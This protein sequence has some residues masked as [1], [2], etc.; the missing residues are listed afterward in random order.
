MIGYLCATPY[1]VIA[2]TTLA[3]GKFK[4]EHN[5]LVIMDHFSIDEPLVKKIRALGIFNEVHLYKSNKKTK[6]NNF[7]RL[8]NAFF[9][10]RIMR[11][12]AKKDFDRFF[13]FAL[14]FI[15]ITYLIKKINKRSEKCEFAFADDGLGSYINEGIYTPTP[16]SERIL[17]LNGRLKLLK[18]VKKLYVYKPDFVIANKEFEL[19]KIPQT[20]DSVHALRRL[21]GALWPLDTDV[22]FDGKIL[23]FEQPYANDPGDK[24]TKEEQALI[25]LIQ[26]EM[27]A[28]SCIKM[29][30]RSFGDAKWEHFDVIESK[31]PMEAMLLQKDCRPC[32]M[33]TNFS[34]ASFASFLLDGIGASGVPTLLMVKLVDNKDLK[35]G[36]LIEKFIDNLNEKLEDR[37]VFIPSDK[38]ELIR[39]IEQI[40]NSPK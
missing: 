22:D 29:H 39:I 3:S 16:T 40:K 12:L 10:P 6:L 4:D 14:N 9:P 35:L 8:V 31:M 17:K 33:T 2:A 30:P 36:E 19:D 18:T 27:E 26:N 15:D 20:E 25:A 21:V 28:P 13:C 5:V 7:K 24:I 11:E 23:H 34:T 32:L 37:S 38:D 1:H